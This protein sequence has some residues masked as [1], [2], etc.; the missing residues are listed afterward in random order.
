MGRA[1]KTHLRDGSG[2]RHYKFIHVDR[3]RHG[4]RRI[5]FRRGR[6]LRIRLRET[7]GTVAFEE[8]YQRAF[9]SQPPVAAAKWVPAA[10]G[11]MRWLC[12][13]Y[14]ASAVFQ[15][16]GPTTRQVRRGILEGICH[17]SVDGQLV[18]SF[19]FAMMEPRHVAKLRDQKIALPAAANARVKAL[20]ALFTWAKARE[21]RY[22]TKNPAAEVPYLLSNNPD[23]F[24]AWT[25]ADV[26]KYEG[27]HPQGTKARLALDL[28][29]Y[30]GVR[31]SDVV[32]LGPQMVR[33]GKL[34]F[35]ETKGRA[36]I[37]KTHELPI[38]PPLQQSLDATTTG[39]LVYLATALASR[40]RSR[41][42][43]PGSS[44]GAARPGSTPICRR[45]GS[46]SWG[47]SAG[48]RPGR[49]NIN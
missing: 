10:P 31:R 28:L 46:E 5:Y 20:R 6:E 36:K 44:G 32:K 4:N 12:E 39:H 2:L 9:G 30:T 18:G 14:Y 48:S 3:D 33:D 26:A 23:G 15:T 47:R 45:T 42:L 24:R 41:D 38:L 25:E 21:Y 29:L 40:T 43:V 22:A 1:V 19:R 37:A 13:Q 7:P 17:Q 34:V 11:T 49:P 27:R 16:L 8:E 35:T